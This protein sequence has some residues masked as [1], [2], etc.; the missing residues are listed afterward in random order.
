MIRTHEAGTLRRGDAGTRVTLTGWVA[1]R[2]DHGGVIFV[3]LRDA[4]GVAQVVFREGEPAEQGHAL[5]PEWCVLVR[6]E[7]RERPAGNENPELPTG[8]VE[9]VADAVEVLSESETPPFPIES[10]PEITTPVDEATRWRDRYLD[11]RRAGPARAIR[12]RARMISVKPW[13]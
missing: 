8:E 2:R 6:G 4:S 10:A 11:L 9:V 1:R 12:T 7:V 13:S 5:R 3:D